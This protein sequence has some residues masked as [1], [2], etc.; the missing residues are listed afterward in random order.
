M[1]DS[2]D[3][4]SLLAILNAHG[5][6]FLQSFPESC[7]GKRPR[8]I[9]HPLSV[10]DSES[11]WGG[12]EHSSESSNSEDE[13]AG[14]EVVIFSEGS[15]KDRLSKP[16]MKTFMSSKISVLQRES[17]SVPQEK[18][19]NDED[20]DKTH[21]QNDA[22]LHRLVH[23]KLLSGS[24]NPELNLPS[25][26]RRKALAGRVLELAGGAKLGQGERSV[27]AAERDKASKRVREGLLAKEKKKRVAELQQAKDLGNYHPTLK[28]NFQE[29]STKARKR[30][31]GLGMGIGKFSSG[32][33]KLDKDDLR[34]VQGP[35]SS[36]GRRKHR[37]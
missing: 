25:A 1:P 31:R 37:K 26:K 28:K 9:S 11:E 27:R 36:Q 23:T 22:L 30:D 2:D 17:V 8:T 33:L 20:D 12:I 18:V 13:E 15:S 32:V 3:E 4:E 19:E 14:P 16:Q 21:A 35:S 6:N 5:Q 34:K 7:L 10:S 24:L 29:S